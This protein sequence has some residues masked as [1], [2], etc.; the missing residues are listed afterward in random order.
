MSDAIKHIFAQLEIR[1]SHY[2]V[3]FSNEADPSA[4]YQLEL[5]K[6]VATLGDVVIDQFWMPIHT[7]YGQR[8][9]R[10]VNQQPIVDFWWAVCGD[11]GS[12]DEKPVQEASLR[13][14]ILP[15]ARSN[16]SRRVFL[17]SFQTVPTERRKL[18]QAWIAELDQR[19]S[20]SRFE[21]YDEEAFRD[22]TADLIGPPIY[23]DSVQQ[24]HAEV[25]DRL[26]REARETIRHEG[27]EA[28]DSVLRN[29]EGFMT[30]IGRRRGNPVEKEVL[31]ILSYECRAA[32][33]RCYSA[34]W[35]LLL[36]ALAYRYSLSDKSYIFHQLWHL[37]RCRESDHGDQGHFH[38]FHGHVFG[39]HPACGPVLLT[40]YGTELFGRWLLEGSLQSYRR[41]LHALAVAVG[42]YGEQHS[43]AALLR[44]KEGQ[45]ET[46]GD[47][48]ALEERE[49]ERRSGRRTKK[50]AD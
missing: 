14:K 43:I 25:A 23:D 40:R 7:L 4:P 9:R 32:L 6:K 46:V 50:A 45:I 47:M 12:R 19:L 24:R 21:E 11:K 18:I 1:E 27:P 26:F 36:P 44:K 17:D 42:F 41:V 3:S 15:H 35:S 8:N 49:T 31:D 2:E 38:L 37:D 22:A 34:V 10:A 16:G 13:A 33:H 48:V 5:L 39:L 20:V 30:S 28:I 29:W